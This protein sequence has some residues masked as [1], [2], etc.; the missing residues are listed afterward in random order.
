M[1]ASGYS[2]LRFAN[3]AIPADIQSHLMKNIGRNERVIITDFIMGP[4]G[5]HGPILPAGTKAK[6]TRFNYQSKKRFVKQV[7]KMLD[8]F[9]EERSNGINTRLVGAT[10]IFRYLNNFGNWSLVGERLIRVIIQRSQIILRDM[11]NI[12]QRMLEEHPSGHKYC[13][14]Y[15]TRRHNS[16]ISEFKILCDRTNNE[17]GECLKKLTELQAQSN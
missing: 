16:R 14:R 5:E 2:R 10:Q 13:T 12:Y 15:Q 9:Q 4:K 8:R 17:V 6:I 7:S 11:D 1:S 3:L